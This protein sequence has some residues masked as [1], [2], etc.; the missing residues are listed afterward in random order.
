MRQIRT[1]IKKETDIA[2]E[3]DRAMK[4]LHER[5]RILDGKV[6]DLKNKLKSKKK[7]VVI[8]PKEVGNRKLFV[9]F[10]QLRKI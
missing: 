9:I 10:R 2:I 5:F 3:N 4:K 6:Y 7:D 1:A 8:P